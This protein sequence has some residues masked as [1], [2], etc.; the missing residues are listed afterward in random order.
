VT[1]NKTGYWFPRRGLHTGHFPLWTWLF[2][3][4]WLILV[5]VYAIW[6]VAILIWFII[7]IPVNLVLLFIRLATRHEPPPVARFDTQTGAPLAPRFNTQTGKR[8]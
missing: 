6:L 7:S 1:T 5:P 8:P 4:F 2:P 3:P